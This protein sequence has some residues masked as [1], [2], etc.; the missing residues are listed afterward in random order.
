MS[1]QDKRDNAPQESVREPG[2][3]GVPRKNTHKKKALLTGV[4]SLSH[5]EGL[6]KHFAETLG[7]TQVVAA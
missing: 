6:V 4:D 3:L 1:E 2:F 5:L 7:N